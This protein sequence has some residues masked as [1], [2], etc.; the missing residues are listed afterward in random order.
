MASR[1]M[2]VTLIVLSTIQ[3]LSAQDWYNANWQ[4]RT[5]VTISNSH[6][7]SI[8][9]SDYQVQIILTS[10]DFDFNNKVLSDGS[11]I[12][13]TSGDGRTPIPFWIENS[14]HAAGPDTI[15]AKVPVIP[16]GD[17]TVFIYYGNPSPPEP[18]QIEVPPTGPYTKRPNKIIPIGDP[19]NGDMLLPENMV[20]DDE[21]GRYWLAFAN[22]RNG[23]IGLIWSD[24]PT[25]T[26]AW[27]WYPD[28]TISSANAP[29]IMEYDG[30]WYLFYATGGHIVA[31]TSDN[32]GGPYDISTLTTVLEDGA[33][34]SWEDYRVDEPYVFQRSDGK[35]ILTY[36]GDASSSPPVEQVGYAF[37][38]N[39]L[40]PY[41]KFPR[42]PII[43][44][45]DAGDF[46]VGV[47]ADPWV[48]Y[49][50]G[51]YYI[52]YAGVNNT[53]GI[54]PN[55]A[56]VTT[57]DWETFTKKPIILPTGPPGSF[58]S[59]GVFRGAVT[60]VEDLYVFIYT[61]RWRASESPSG[62]IYTMGMATQ[63][64]VKTDP[65]NDPKE[66][67]DF[68]EGF[69]DAELN[70]NNWYTKLQV[71]GGT[72]SLS[73]GKLI[74]IG[75]STSADLGQV[76]VRSSLPQYYGTI[77]ECYGAHPTNVPPYNQ[78]NLFQVGNIQ[79]DIAYT[80]V[81]RFKDG[82]EPGQYEF[83]EM[84]ATKANVQ[85]SNISTPFRF[86]EYPPE[87]SQTYGVYRPESGVAKF[88]IN[89]SPFVTFN[90]VNVPTIAPLYPWLAAYANPG[91]ASPSRFEV[92][93]VRIRKFVETEPVVLSVSEQRL[94]KW[95][96]SESA[97][98]ATPGNWFDAT[99]A[100]GSGD[101]ATIPI[102]TTTY[103]VINN[104]YTINP[105]GSLTIEAGAELTVNGDLTTSD[106]LFIESTVSS[107]SGSLIV[108]GNSTGDVTY[109]RF[110]RDDDDASDDEDKHLFSSP[111]GG[112]DI[113][114]FILN[115]ELKI[116]SVRIWDEEDGV[117]SR[118]TEGSFESGKGY[119]VY[120]RAGS[121]GDFSFTGTLVGTAT[122]RTSSPYV[123]DYDS[124]FALDP[125]DAF[126]EYNTD[127]LYWAGDRSWNNYG[128]GGW[129]LLGN[130][131][132]SS[133]RITDSDLDNTND[134]L[135]LN[136]PSFD[137]SYVAVYVYD[138]IEGQY[139]YKGKSTG[140]IDPTE[141]PV[142]A[143]FGYNDIQAGQGFF[144]LANN[145]EADFLFTTVLQTHSTS[146]PMTKSAKTDNSWP[147][148]QL[149]A[150]C[151]NSESLTTVF[152]HETM[153][154]GLDKGYDVGQF[155][156][157][158]EINIY[159]SLFEKDNGVNFARQGLPL[160]GADKMHIP[161]G[162]DTEKG[163]EVTFSAYSV[164]I[165]INKYWLED[166]ATGIFTDL[167]TKSYT[168]T[169]PAKTYGT[170]RFYIIASANTP[171]GIKDIITEDTGLRIWNAYDKII[172]KGEVSEKALCEVYNL[173]GKKILDKQ[174]KGGEMNI[175]DLPAGIRG[176]YLVRVTDGVKATTR[177]V[178]FP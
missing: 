146:V 143:D 19:G 24:D 4:Y 60:R 164:P 129:N 166:K 29:H 69:N 41:T 31:R 119:N 73:N 103:P 101:N 153:T 64:A 84:R 81:L 86:S 66:V 12:R 53:T 111:V 173:Q 149:K 160:E 79:Y 40:G 7:G 20:R 72:A 136:Q 141:D 92:D 156:A 17:T 36:M 39:I 118:V 25:N 1:V 26:V 78:T 37:A 75:N 144:V 97:D 168:V 34:G 114:D 157:G 10:P 33:S 110:L 11:D 109:N 28:F 125:D 21:T 104:N 112:Q 124:R 74:L 177:K 16:V 133:L 90:T 38:D 148:I 93:W 171:T 163:G 137:P 18:G 14:W 155:S 9:L 49:H 150:S 145:D 98:W 61:A 87:N 44:F 82:G 147:G 139:L 151:R 57:T 113:S 138:G 134:F 108:S 172:I 178:A 80:N 122:I 67:F 142:N 15:W 105:E 159:T 162:V 35:W 95:D 126:G 83:Y 152:F 30:T 174:L 127:P 117:W 76:S 89:N 165:G 121:D 170:G 6:P 48:Y 63:P 131:F 120:Q 5:Q 56:Y 167:T 13:V 123:L 43:P 50:N 128:G 99:N 46:D 2:A 27:N 68:Y 130:P 94:F 161:I 51:T 71:V 88:R 140:F 3:V 42:N 55:T 54:C 135:N 158:R 62:Q 175:V 58:D 70:P 59:F 154:A 47:V 115:H 45:G 91:M 116:D 65:I 8:A 22:Y 169:L 132:T 85:G 102:V 52:G 106:G 100:P 107:G 96:G 32:P 23:S 77:M 176:V